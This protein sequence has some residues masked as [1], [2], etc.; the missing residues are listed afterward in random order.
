MSG[1]TLY[2]FGVLPDTR[3]STAMTQYA[4]RLFKRSSLINFSASAETEVNVS[5]MVLQ[6]TSPAQATPSSTSTVT[7]NAAFLQEIK[8][9]DQE[10]WELLRDARSLCS[11]PETIRRHIKETVAM[12]TRLQDQLALHFSLEEYYGYFDDPVTVAPQLSQKANALW[13]EHRTLYLDIVA[14]VDRA[15]HLLYHRYHRHLDG[16]VRHIALRFNGFYDQLKAHEHAEHQLIFA[17]FDDDL[18]VGD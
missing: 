10:L 7:V 5:T 4:F 8:E 16:L 11:H 17:A 9:V 12:L 2:R 3:L 18:G 6:S 14:I 15:E 13:A 1:N